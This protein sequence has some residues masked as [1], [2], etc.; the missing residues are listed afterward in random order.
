V[1]PSL[2]KELCGTHGRKLLGNCGRDKLVDADAVLS[3]ASLDLGLE[4]TRQAE[5]VRC[6]A[7]SCPDPP[8]RF[9]RCQHNNAKRGRHD[10]EIP[11]VEGYDRCRLTVHGG[12]EDELVLRIARRYRSPLQPQPKH[13]FEARGINPE[14]ANPPTACAADLSMHQC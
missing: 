5:K 7:S 1:F 2:S 8:D 11:S 12:I 13:H 6:F 3:G 9:G 10:A 14:R 4:R